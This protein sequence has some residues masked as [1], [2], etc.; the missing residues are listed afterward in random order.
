VYIAGVARAVPAF[1]RCTMPNL[2][3]AFIAGQA[4]HDWADVSTDWE[5][6]H[7]QWR[8][9]GDA[10]RIGGT[11]WA[12]SARDAQR[13]ADLLGACLP[14]P[15][16]LDARHDQAKV[17]IAPHTQRGCPMTDEAIRL[18]SQLIDAD[19]SSAGHGIVSPVGKQWVV[20]K[21]E[22]CLYGWH[23]PS[24]V[25]K[26][27]R[28]RW[29]GI[30]LREAQ[31]LPGVYV[32][33]SESSGN[34]SIDHFD[35]SMFLLLVHGE[36]IVNGQRMA[37]RD[38]YTDP[39]LCGLAT[40]S[41][42]PLR[43]ARYTTV[44]EERQAATDPAT[45]PRGTIGE[46]L[47]AWYMTELRNGVCEVPPGSNTGPRIREYHSVAM[48]DGR[49]LGLTKGP[50]CASMASYGLSRL[51]PPA[52]FVPRCSGY[53]L[54]QDA[55]AAGAWR[56]KPSVV[57]DICILSRPGEAWQRHVCCVVDMPDDSGHFVTVGGNE[58]DR[59]KVTDRNMVDA[60]V[61]G[62]ICLPRPGAV[63]QAGAALVDAAEKVA[64][65]IREMGE[66]YG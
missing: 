58:G 32:I 65:A 6:H 7:A 28:W 64:K 51:T 61:R 29:R 25:W 60:A 20:G 55:K 18:H 37:T 16:L 10:A 54:E 27:G 8:M 39:A 31:T 56:D 35:Y 30:P 46:Q 13:I 2:L 45:A 42:T 43:A 4:V 19:V 3:D 17:K 22:P 41:S 21:S 36:V 66:L 5:G 26:A 24:A 40:G 49:R 23:T 15:A 62:F 47:L 12:C 50:W 53:E 44:P 9:L 1:L 34:H 14:T 59:V 33:Q 48:R 57:G 38:V 63:E 52:W 11:R